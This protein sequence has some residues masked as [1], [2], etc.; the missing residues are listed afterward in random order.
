MFVPL[1][2]QAAPRPLKTLTALLVVTGMG[3]CRE[4]R[5]RKLSLGKKLISSDKFP[6]SFV[7]VLPHFK[8][9]QTSPEI[10]PKRVLT[11]IFITFYEQFLDRC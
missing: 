1:S 10:F 3:F 2:V 9:D 6:L 4:A 7:F 11:D 5:G 8:Y